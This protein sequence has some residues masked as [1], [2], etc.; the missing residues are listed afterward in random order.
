M[1]GILLRCLT[2][3]VEKVEWMFPFFSAREP[4][5]NI[6]VSDIIQDNCFFSAASRF[7]SI[8]KT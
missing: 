8:L 4:I 5:Y 2:T 1:F 7:E 6:A 3:D